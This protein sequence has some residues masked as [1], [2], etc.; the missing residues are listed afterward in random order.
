MHIVIVG[1]GLAGVSAAWYL[2]ERGH[3]V[4]VIDRDPGPALEASYANGGQISISH[5]EPWSNPGAPLQIIKWLGRK[6][7]PLLFRWPAEA[8]RIHWGLQ[9]LR[10]C[11]PARS[12]RNTVSIARLAAYSGE[13]LRLLREATG[14]HYD[15]L[16][17]GVLHLYFTPAGLRHGQAQFRVLRELGI[18][19]CMLD[20]AQCV[21]TEP[22]LLRIRDRIAGGMLGT[23]DESGDAQRFASELAA[24]CAAA[25]VVFHYDTEVGAISHADGR[26]TGLELLRQGSREQLAAD[27]YVLAAGAW[28][29]HLARALGERLPIYPVK[30]YSATL[31]I[32]DARRAPSVSLTD[33][34]RRIVCSRLGDRLRIAGTAELNG[35]DTD[36]DPVRSQALLRWVEDIFPGVCALDEPNAWAGLR[37]TTP[38]N[39]P[40][41]GRSRRMANLYYNTGHGTLGWTLAAGS[42]RALADIVDQRPPAVDFPFGG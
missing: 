37:P 32:Q 7:A 31:R 28:S 11:L 33:E 24:R 26:I 34:A 22:S 17:R 25:G 15:E 29:P 6:D 19:A 4:S 9:F 40:I 23:D 38:S 16:S 10:E 5:P 14:I 35:Y 18:G 20:A 1:A 13:Q 41:I 12:Q 2:R 27:A 36:I 21:E 42:A 39:L 30:G 8:A 3:Q